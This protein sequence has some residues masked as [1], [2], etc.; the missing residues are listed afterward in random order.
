MKYQSKTN[1]K[2]L[3][4]SSFSRL[5]NEHVLSKTQCSNLAAQGIGELHISLASKRAGT[6]RKNFKIS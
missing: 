5:V 2:K 3:Y 6:E 1:K 4:L